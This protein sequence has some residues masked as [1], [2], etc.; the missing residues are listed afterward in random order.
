MLSNRSLCR[1]RSGRNVHAKSAFNKRRN[2]KQRRIRTTRRN[3]QSASLAERRSVI[4]STRGRV[5][6][7]VWH[8]TDAEGFYVVRIPD[9]GD[10][11]AVFTVIDEVS[12][13][14]CVDFA[15]A[16]I[17]LSPAWL[18]YTRCCD[19]LIP[20]TYRQM[21]KHSIPARAC[22][23]GGAATQQVLRPCAPDHLRA[24]TDTV[25]PAG[26]HRC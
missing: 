10:P 15:T 9:T 8:E 22:T 13:C 2:Q 23:N 19:D 7:G 25:I 5:I 20:P 21:K 24:R 16:W 14:P 12:K 18:S 26:N 1:S 6:G 4:A 3:E 11:R 17:R